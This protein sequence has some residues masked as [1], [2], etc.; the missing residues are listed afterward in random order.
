[1]A[2]GEADQVEQEV[3]AVLPGGQPIQIAQ[4]V[5]PPEA[6]LRLV[7]DGRD[8]LDGGERLGPLLGIGQVRVEQGQVELDVH[9]LLEQLPAQV[10]PRLGGVDVLVEVEHEVVGHDRVAGGEERDQPVDQV[11]F[12]V[13]HGRQVGQVAVQVHLLDRPG[14]ADGRPVALVEIRVAHGP[15]GQV[16]SGVEQHHW[17]A[18]QI[19]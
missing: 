17:H 14:V 10:E 1:D 16:H 12:R 19:S 4:R 3:P 7:A 5:D 2:G 11:P 9:R 18:S 15:Q 8:V 13:A 6:E